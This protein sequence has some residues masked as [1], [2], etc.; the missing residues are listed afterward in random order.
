MSRNSLPAASSGDVNLSDTLQAGYQQLLSAL[1]TLQHRRA[2]VAGQPDSDSES[3][4]LAVPD[5]A[6]YSLDIELRQERVVNDRVPSKAVHAS[7]SRGSK[8]GL[9]LARA[10]Q[11][12][13]APHKR[14]RCVFADFF[15]G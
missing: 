11:V 6:L 5:V 3:V 12:D 2:Q 14:R 7:P 10:Q 8:A 9:R 1:K 13:A 4:A 15:A